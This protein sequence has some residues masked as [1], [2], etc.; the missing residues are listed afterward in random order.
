MS[1]KQQ[2]IEARAMSKNIIASS[3]NMVST[4]PLIQIEGS[5]CTKMYSNKHAIASRIVVRRQFSIFGFVDDK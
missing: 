1:R 3:R 4:V 2:I 5:R